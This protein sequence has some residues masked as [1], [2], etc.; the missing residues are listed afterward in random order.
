MAIKISLESTVIPVEIGDLKFEIDVSDEKYE[1]IVERFNAFLVKM[2]ALDE[3]NPEDV[4][5]LKVIVK[6][7]YDELLGEK[8]YEQIHAKMPNISFVAGLL[9]D[10][11]TQLTEEV[12][13]R[14]LPT[15]KV[16]AVVKKQAK[17][18]TKK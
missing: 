13:K 17:K 12:N 2:E 8:S 6:E 15:A 11:V 18:Q 5:K 14:T 7:M 16:K 3:D 4:G 1:S 10:L 9:A